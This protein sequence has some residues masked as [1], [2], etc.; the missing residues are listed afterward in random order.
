[1][2]IM[3]NWFGAK[4]RGFIF[5]TWT[6][7]QY[8][9]NIVAALVASAILSSP[10]PWVWALLIPAIANFIW[11]CVCYA[12]LPARP[13]D[14]GVVTE[15]MAARALTTQQHKDD[16]ETSTPSETILPPPISFMDALRIPNVLSYA[17]AFGFF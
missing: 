17:F 11:G 8:V 1:T 14:V 6:C 7:H 2:A 4:N 5:G 16:G 12:Y 15:E 3:G 13:E 9:G 10:L